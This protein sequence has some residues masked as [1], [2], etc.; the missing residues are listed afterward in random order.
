M[1]FTIKHHIKKSQNEELLIFADKKIVNKQLST[2]VQ[3]DWHSH[4]M[5]IGFEGAIAWNNVASDPLYKNHS[6]KNNE[7]EIL[8]SLLRASKPCTFV[9]LGPGEGTLDFNLLKKF[10]STINDLIY[11]PVDISDGLL[12]LTINKL[13]TVASVPFGIL[14]NIE[15]QQFFLKKQIDRI[16]KSPVLYSLLGN[17]LGNLDKN[18]QNFFNNFSEIMSKNDSILLNISIISDKW[19]ASNDPRLS[20]K[21]YPH[22]VRH[23]LMR[24]AFQEK[25]DSLNNLISNFQDIVELR[26]ETS[27]NIDY[28]EKIQIY[29][30]INNRLITNIRR[31]RLESFIYWLN[32]STNLRVKKFHKKFYSN[33]IGEGYLL[34]EKR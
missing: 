21:Y 30:K 26:I 15:E 33:E 5:Y 25:K 20:H 8:A 29:N 17:T 4:T 24:A 12:F 18:E 27:K 31:Y 23:F 10:S 9:S 6:L 2:S 3:Q 13:S 14:N 16:G 22:S 34:I 19:I 32:N 7:I 11:I 28:C 1:D